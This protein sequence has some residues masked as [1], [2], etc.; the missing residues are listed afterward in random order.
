MSKPFAV[1][2]EKAEKQLDKIP[3][4]YS[5]D[6][7]MLAGIGYAVLALAKAVEDIAVELNKQRRGEKA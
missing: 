7:G 2:A 5:S 6:A 1:L 4:R 3:E